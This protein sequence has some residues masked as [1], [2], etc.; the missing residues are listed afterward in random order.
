M[1]GMSFP[2]YKGPLTK[3][4]IASHCFRCGTEKTSATILG[5]DGGVGVCE[6]HEP[7]VSNLVPEQ[8]LRRKL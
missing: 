8:R 6:K 4:F 5:K 3:E 2:Q 1:S 7:L